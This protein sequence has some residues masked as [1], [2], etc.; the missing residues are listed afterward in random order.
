MMHESRE[1]FVSSEDGEK[2][3]TIEND[4]RKLEVLVEVAILCK[5]GTKKPSGLQETEAKSGKSNKIPQ[6]KAPAYGI[7]CTK[8][9]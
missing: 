4:R 7:I 6:N 2:K 8:R 5:R 9:S 1:V 3:E